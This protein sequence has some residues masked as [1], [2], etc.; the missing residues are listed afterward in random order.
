MDKDIEFLRNVANRIADALY[1]GQVH[2][3]GTGG[4]VSPGLMHD[5]YDRLRDLANRLEIK[6][7][8]ERLETLNDNQRKRKST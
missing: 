3:I 1:Y 8:Q 5:D 2:K 7:L 4:I 6:E